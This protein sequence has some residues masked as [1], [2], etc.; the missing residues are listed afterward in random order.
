[1]HLPATRS[2]LAHAL[3]GA[4]ALLLLGGC[5]GKEPEPPE[6]CCTESPDM[7]G[8]TSTQDMSEATEPDLA[9]PEPEDMPEEEPEDTGPIFPEDLDSPEPDMPQADLTPEVDM[10]PAGLPTTCEGS[11]AEQTLEVEFGAQ[12]VPIERAVFGLTAPEASESGQWELHIEALHGG[13]EGCPNQGSPTPE[14]TL[15]VSGLALPEL[16]VDQTW[17]QGVRATLLD[18]QG[19]LVPDPPFFARA[20]AVTA[21]SVAADLCTEC[22]GDVTRPDPEGF[23][24]LD[25]QS[26]FEQGTVGGRLYAL[27]CQSMDT[28]TAGE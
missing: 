26:T 6:T 2:I 5:P 12:R 14:R 8:Q 17:D 10:D 3:L 1:M 20:T 11:C 4:G 18:F 19:D 7:P 27:H 23:V 15:I 16:G 13:F 24:A 25:V 9:D 28:A 22:V 21:S